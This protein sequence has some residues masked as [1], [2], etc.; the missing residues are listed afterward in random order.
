MKLAV[1]FGAVVVLIAVSACTSTGVKKPQTTASETLEITKSTQPESAQNSELA[2]QSSRS[3]AGKT[4]NLVRM[5]DGGACKND[6][7][8]VKG[9]FLLYA[10]PVAVETIQAQRGVEVFTEFENKIQTFS[11]EALQEAVNKTDFT[12][13]PFA[14]DAADAQL[15]VSRQFLDHFDNA[16]APA[17]DA[18]EQDSGLPIDVKAFFSSL[19]FYTQGCE[20]TY[21]HEQPDDANGF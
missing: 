20:A 12:P 18:F 19:V 6:R 11:A 14:L 7:E 13:D 21:G 9:I 15:K 2:P 5:L 17:I 4:L 8:G 10:D 1:R 3:K 16:I